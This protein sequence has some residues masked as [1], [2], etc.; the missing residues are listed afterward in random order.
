MEQVRARDLVTGLHA[1]DCAK[2]C[3]CGQKI[4]DENKVRDETTICIC[5]V[6]LP[7]SLICTGTSPQKRV[8]NEAIGVIHNT[9]HEHLTSVVSTLPNTYNFV[10]V[11][12]KA[13]FSF[14]F[15]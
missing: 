13:S 5:L 11:L 6:N 8:Q 12:Q 10:L 4:L 1:R 9:N 14:Q 2:T 3:V 15:H 7:L